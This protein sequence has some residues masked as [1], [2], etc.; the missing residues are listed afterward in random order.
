MFVRYTPRMNSMHGFWMAVSRL[1]GQH[2]FYSAWW[3]YWD[4][5]TPVE[6]AYAPLV[7]AATAWTAAIRGIPRDVA[8]ETV[9]GLVY[10]LGPVTLFL[11]A[12]LWTRAPGYAFA[13]A[14]F[15]SLAA[16]SQLLLPDLNSMRRLWYARRLYVMAVWDE[17]PHMAALALL[18]LVILFL[19]LAIRRRR[20][21]YYAAAT[22][23]IVA[24]A[25]A[26]DFGPILA[27]M[28]SLCLL[29]VLRRRDFVRNLLLTA[30]IGLIS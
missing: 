2:W 8:F 28:A 27:A 10:C 13:A 24:C 1:G 16:P 5:G 7:P 14:V 19:S 20:R 23:A 21:R 30:G 11:M 15:Y 12:W 22:L 3:R 17:T 29:F 25:L 4:C 9:S 6:F 18:P 26:S